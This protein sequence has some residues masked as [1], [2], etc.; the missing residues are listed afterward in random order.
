MKRWQKSLVFLVT[1]VLMTALGVA[2]MQRRKESGPNAQRDAWV[3][4]N[5]QVLSGYMK[6]HETRMSFKEMNEIE[7]ISVVYE[8]ATAGEASTWYQITGDGVFGGITVDRG[9]SNRNT[10]PL[11][12]GALPIDWGWNGNPS[13]NTFTAAGGT[14]F[15]DEPNV[16]Q[17]G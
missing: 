2:V 14:P 9:R 10:D 7:V 1:L 3:N 16:F 8:Q 17:D 15:N 11:P 12:N 5:W 6:H 4:D 13:T